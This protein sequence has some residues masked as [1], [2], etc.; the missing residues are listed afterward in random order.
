MKINILKDN[1]VKKVSK[2]SYL[3][4]FLKTWNVYIHT[5]VIG[6]VLKT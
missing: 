2:A 5:Y 1:L 4:Q 3:G 6:M